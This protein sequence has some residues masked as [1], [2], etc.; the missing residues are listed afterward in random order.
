L[1]TSLGLHAGCQSRG[2]AAV[3]TGGVMQHLVHYRRCIDSVDGLAF[4]LCWPGW[5]KPAVHGQQRPAATL[6]SIV[7]VALRNCPAIN[8]SKYLAYGLLLGGQRS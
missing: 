3:F 4:V 5:L 7:I 6:R 2:G 8:K 1:P